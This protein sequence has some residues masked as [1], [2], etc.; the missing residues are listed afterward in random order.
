MSGMSLHTC[1]FAVSWLLLLATCGGEEQ[2]NIRLDRPDKVGDTYSQSVQAKFKQDNL[3]R[4]RDSLPR[5]Q[6]AEF[7]VELEGT[8]KVLAVDEQNRQATKLSC[9]VAKLVRDGQPVLAEGTIVIAENNKGT[10]RYTVDDQAVDPPVAQSL[11]EVLWTSRGDTSDNDDTLFG[12]NQ[13]RKVGD[14]WSI[15]PDAAVRTF[16]RDGVEVSKD[17]VAGTVGLTGAKQIDGKTFLSVA[18]HANITGLRGVLPDA[19][20]VTDGTLSVRSDALIP[21]DGQ[22]KRASQTLHWRLDLQVDGLTLSDEPV[23]VDV[24]IERSASVTIKE[25]GK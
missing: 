7:S 22:G 20:V 5:S 17:R 9:T 13:P 23:H 8:V 21:A 18:A 25:I 3:S 15:N 10:T 2:Y 4:V 19:T 11:R 24:T 16:S 1:S 14:S 6:Q 12:T